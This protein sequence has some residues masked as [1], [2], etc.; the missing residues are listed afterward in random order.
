[1]TLWFRALSRFDAWGELEPQLD[2]LFADTFYDEEKRTQ[3]RDGFIE[4]LAW[5][6]ARL[7]EDNR[8]AEERRAAMDRV[9]PKYVLRNYLAQEVI[10]RAEQGDT[11]GIMKQG[12]FPESCPPSSH[13]DEEGA[14]LRYQEGDGVERRWGEGRE[15]SFCAEGRTRSA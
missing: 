12:Y 5:Y 9:N 10:D 4:W 11:A 14:R 2:T 3:T 8:S 1:M 6:T 7:R 13:A 15:E